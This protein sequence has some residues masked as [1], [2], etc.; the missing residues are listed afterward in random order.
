MGAFDDY[1]DSAEAVDEIP[2]SSNPEDGAY[3]FLTD[4]VWVYEFPEDHA[5]NPGQTAYVWDLLITEADN[6]AMLGRHFS[7]WLRKPNV[8]LQGK[9]K[10]A[11]FASILKSNMLRFGIPEGV[12]ATFDFEDEDHI[13]T[14]L[15]REG[16]GVLKTKNG[17]Q[18]LVSYELDEDA[19]D[20]GP[21]SEEHIAEL[22]AW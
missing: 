8:A 15:N 9:D 14:V 16:Y 4:K 22:P 20:A 7:V 3:K 10:A 17:F 11:T 5:K 12:L 6:E 21:A 18:N 2:T 1:V 19:G 13:E